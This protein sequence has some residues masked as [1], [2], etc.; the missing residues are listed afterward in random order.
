[1]NKQQIKEKVEKMVAQIGYKATQEKINLGYQFIACSESLTS[2]DYQTL[3]DYN[4]MEKVLET[5]VH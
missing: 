2:E 5:I 3:R 1:M 4:E